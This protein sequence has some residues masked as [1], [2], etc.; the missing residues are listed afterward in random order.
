MKGLSRENILKY[1][2]ELSIEIGKEGIKGEIFLRNSP[3]IVSKTMFS[4]LI[5]A[6]GWRVYVDAP[7][8]RIIL[9]NFSQDLRIAEVFFRL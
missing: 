3:E 8:W 7:S 4:P 1:L 9:F 5:N 2:E 6:P